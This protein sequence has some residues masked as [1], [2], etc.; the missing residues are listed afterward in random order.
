MIAYNYNYGRKLNN[1]KQVGDTLEGF[2]YSA[3][4]KLGL[5]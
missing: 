1:W 4:E 3:A 5:M 2:V